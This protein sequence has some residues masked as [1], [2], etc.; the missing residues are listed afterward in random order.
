MNFWGC[1]RLESIANLDLG[2][3]REAAIRVLEKRSRR[4]ELMKMGLDFASSCVIVE[5]EFNLF[6]YDKA[7]NQ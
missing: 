5:R 6:Q 1:S 2:Q 3:R 4:R 7:R